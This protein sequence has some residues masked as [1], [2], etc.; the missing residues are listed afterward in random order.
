MLEKLF[1]FDRNVT[2]VRTE[3]LAGIMLLR[4]EGQQ[5]YLQRR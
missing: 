5:P 1:G 3:V 4:Q 2:R